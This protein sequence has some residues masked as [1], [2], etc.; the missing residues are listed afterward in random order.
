MI[1]PMNG[2]LSSLA[3]QD[4]YDLWHTRFGHLSKNALRQAPLHVTGL[5]TI[6]VP[7]SSPSCKGYAMGKMAD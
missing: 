3:G 7:A 2:V 4:S 1:T 6:P 5:P